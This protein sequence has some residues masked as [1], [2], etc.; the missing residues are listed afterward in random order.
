MTD[1]PRG[2]TLKR[3]KSVEEEAT[4]AEIVGVVSRTG[5]RLF[6]TEE[7]EVRPP[8]GV[9]SFNCL[10]RGLPEVILESKSG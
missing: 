10:A 1:D 5:R 8:D 6:A 9:R 3:A 2:S 7:G 4:G